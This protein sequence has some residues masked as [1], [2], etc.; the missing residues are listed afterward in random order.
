MKPKYLYHG[1]AKKLIGNKLIPKQA[2]DLAEN[3]NNILNGIYA[4][5]LKDEAIAMALLKCKGVIGGASVQIRNKLSRNKY[6]IEAI[7]YGGWPKQKYIFLY[8]LPSTYCDV[9]HGL[10]PTA[11]LMK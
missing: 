3:P 7:V 5:S 4:S 2:T 6:N 10:K 9:L 8:T 11:S 1:S